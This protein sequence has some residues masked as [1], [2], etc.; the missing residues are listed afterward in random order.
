AIYPT[1]DDPRQS[2][3]VYRAPDED[4][5]RDSI[6]G[7]GGITFGGKS[8]D[9]PDEGGGIGVNSFLWRA[10]LD[11]IAFM[12]LSSADP[13]GGVIITDWYSP[14][15]SPKERFKINIYILSK[16]LR[17]DGLRVS[18]FHQV[19]AAGGEWTEAP[20]QVASEIENTVLTKA[21]QLRMATAEP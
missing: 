20:V 11:T 21:R 14:P 18:V 13:F 12:P 15:E 10:A 9:K 1:K 16:T 17:S 8:H 19:R 3:P 6:F 2:S 7:T 5:K 4:V